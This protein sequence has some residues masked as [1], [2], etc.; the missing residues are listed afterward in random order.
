MLFYFNLKYGATKKYADWLAEMTGYDCAETKNA[1]AV[2]L[3]PYDVILL[4][5]GVYAS[6]I[7]GFQFIKKNIGQ[8]ADKKIAVFAVGASPYDEKAILQMRDLHFKNELRS[9]PLFY[10][11]GAWD[12]ETMKFTDRALCK[13]LQKAV[14]KQ[15]PD[16]YEPWQKALMCT[17]GQKCDWTDQSY[18]EPLLKQ[19]ENGDRKIYMKKYVIVFLIWVMI[20]P[21]AILNGGFREYVLMVHLEILALPLSGIILSVCIFLVAYLFVPKIKGCVKRDYILFGVMWFVLTNLFDLSSYIKSGEGFAGLLQSYNILT[22]N[23]WILVV[24]SALISP[25]LVMKIKGRK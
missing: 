6:G 11:R 25:M 7:A 23:T 17:V 15:N 18:L 12:E 2:D 1:N 24:L 4:G 10:C 19:I 14:A 13:M 3:K 5:G 8:L 20:I 16:E 22:G 21:I 9:I